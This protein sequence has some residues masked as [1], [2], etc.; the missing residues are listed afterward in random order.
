M[1]PLGQVQKLF[2]P[3]LLGVRKGLD[4][5]PS[6]CA[7]KHRTDGDKEDVDER[8][9]LPAV[10]PWILQVQKVVDQTGDGDD[11]ETG[12]GSKRG[13]GWNREQNL[14]QDTTSTEILSE[15]SLLAQTAPVAMI[16]WLPIS[17]GC[18][19]S[20]RVLPTQNDGGFPGLKADQ[21]LP[22]P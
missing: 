6:V 21:P 4:A 16:L 1:I 14:H 10:D 9:I 2:E 19:P 12:I 3:L 5:S 8:M 11:C 13:R 22:Q 15:V 7:A 18:Q 17:T 20:I